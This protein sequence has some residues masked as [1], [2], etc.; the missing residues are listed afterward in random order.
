VLRAAMLELAS[1][2]EAGADALVQTAEGQLDVAIRMEML[3]RA[4]GYSEAASDIRT[5]VEDY[6][7]DE[8]R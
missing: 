3:G 7:S 4:S 1:A 8:E 5:T 2:L 6:G